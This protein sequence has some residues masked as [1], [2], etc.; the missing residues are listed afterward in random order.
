ML[1]H[2]DTQPQP[3]SQPGHLVLDIGNTN[4]VLGVFQNQK[5]QRHWRLNT[6]KTITTDEALILLHSIVSFDSALFNN[7]S[8]IAIAS[9]VPAIQDQWNS[10]LSSFFSVTPF[11]VEASQCHSFDIAIDYPRQ[12]GADRL[13]NILA[14]QALGL[15]EAIVIDFGT[16]TTFDVIDNKGN[17]IGGAIA[18][19]IETSANYLLV[20][21]RYRYGGNLKYST[22]Y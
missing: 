1:S 18:P 4:I 19:G 6:R 12:I 21:G 17:F 20:L 5:L 22:K 7:I 14:C 13:C 2:R 3:S 11:W 10:A 16:A 9:V 8:H 15:T